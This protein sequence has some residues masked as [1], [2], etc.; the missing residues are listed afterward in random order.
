MA[1]KVIKEV[2]GSDPLLLNTVKDFL[3]VDYDEDDTLLTSLISQTRDIIEEYLSISMV[4]TKVTLTAS[5]R[6]ELRLPYGPVLTV[7]S[8]KDADGND[9]DYVWDGLC[10][11]FGVAGTYVLNSTYNQN[12]TTIYNTGYTEFPRGLELGWLEIIAWLYEN[13]GDTSGL[14]YMLNRN[15]NLMPYRAKLWF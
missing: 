2:T 12:S 5:P 11:K 6:A 8:V 13:R 9:M 15:T 3:R 4:A 7:T 1:L 10:I 14:S